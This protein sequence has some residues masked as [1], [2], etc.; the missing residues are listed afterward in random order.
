MPASSC[1]DYKNVPPFINDDAGRADLRGLYWDRLVAS[2]VSGQEAVGLVG[3]VTRDTTSGKPVAAVQIIAH[4]VNK[5]TEASAV[6]GADGIYTFTNLE[7]GPYEVAATKNGFQKSAMH[8]EV[9]ARQTARV[10]LPAANRGNVR[11]DH[12]GIVL[13]RGRT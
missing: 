2:G 3:G 5:G 8:V 12:R 9:V 1:G 4:S 6:T 13:D 7:P 10:D 11:A